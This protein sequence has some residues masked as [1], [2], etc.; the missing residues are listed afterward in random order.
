[1]LAIAADGDI[2]CLD[3]ARQYVADATIQF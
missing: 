3:V 2:F 1:V